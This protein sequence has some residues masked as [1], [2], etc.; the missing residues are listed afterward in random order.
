VTAGASHSKA[1]APQGTAPL[2]SIVPSV[3]ALT[4]KPLLALTQD[5]KL[6]EALRHASGTAHEVCVATSEIDLATSLVAHHAGV[7][8]LDTAALTTPAATLTTR[9]HAQFPE[10]VLVVAGSGQDQGTVTAQLT[11]G[12]VH[13]FLHKPL[14]EQRAR[15]FVE[16]AWKRHAETAATVPHRAAKTVHRERRGGA[17]AWLLLLLAAAIAG[18]YAWMRWQPLSAP[19]PQ[20]TQRTPAA[21]RPTPAA[22]DAAL[23][24]LLKRADAAFAAG[25][26]VT[27]AGASAA[28]L[29]REALGRNGRDPRAVNGLEQV[30]D[31]LLA[32]ADAQLQAR[33]LDEAQQLAN[34]AHGISPDH[35]RVAFLLAQIGAQRER[36]VIDRAQRAAA[37]GNVAGALAVLDDAARGGRRSTLVETAREQL[38]QK[39]VDDRVGEFLRRGQEAL[40]RGALIEPAEQNARFFVESARALAPSD[41]AVTAA[42]VEL[43]TRLHTAASQ[44][45][46]AGNPDQAELSIAA[47]ADLGASAAEVAA[48]RADVQKLRGDTRAESLAQL[49]LAFNER[50][51]NGRLTEPAA[52]SARFYLTQLQQ[53]EPDNAATRQASGAYQ[54]RVLDEAR[55]ALRAQ[56]YPLAR[57][58]LAEARA[59]GADAAG[60]AAVESAIATAQADAQR[61]ASFVSAGSLTRTHYVAPEFPVDARQ[62]GIEGWV[63]LQFTVNTDGSVGELTV[64]GAQPVGVFEQSALEAVRRWHYA[65]VLNA[66][67]AISQRARM[68]VRF[69]MQR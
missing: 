7:V 61:Q 13:R 29:Y 19:V 18:T 57:R 14:S 42:V 50:L 62:R 47:M 46:A 48:L 8:V 20:A 1:R 22:P 59:A 44:A 53:A 24:S 52:D 39:Q 67:Q 35:P 40:E 36:A 43:V 66:G 30:I 41:A 34:Q 15:L 5:A 49:A 58:W 4:G 25:Q 54:A 9:L 27:P 37:N 65:P 3:L 12:T 10:V 68:R 21:P 63:D 64:I 17:R 56:D 45:L 60:T 2:P 69:A 31:K 28:D 33:H 51:A 11:D 6:L 32:D 55:G 26:L 16:S 23:E 38:A